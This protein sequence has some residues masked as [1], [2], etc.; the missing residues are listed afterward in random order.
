[1]YYLERLAISAS[2]GRDIDSDD[3]RLDS[4][5]GYEPAA[6]LVKAQGMGYH[7]KSKF[8]H[9]A[10]LITSLPARAAQ[11]IVFT[12]FGASGHNSLTLPS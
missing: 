7:R 11:A 3:V 10:Q 2:R 5:I 6:Y 4:G 9:A 12:L 1:M 8:E